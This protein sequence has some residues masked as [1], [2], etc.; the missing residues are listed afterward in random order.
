MKAFV[1]IVCILLSTASAGFSSAQQPGRS[2]GLAGFAASF[3]ETP[4]AEATGPAL[5]L[6]EAERIAL[7]RNPEIEVAARRVGAA[8]AHVPVAG[9]LDDP[10]VMYRAWGVPLQQPWNYNAAQNMFSISQ[11]FPGGGKR[12]LRT[13]VA[14]SDVDVAKARLDEVRL[15]VR[16]RVHK[17]FDDLLRADDE[18]RIH[19]EHVAI[20][21]QAIEAARIKYSVGKVSQQDILKAQVALTGLAEHM[22]RF[23][24]DADLAR[25]R[26]NTL[27]RRDPDRPLRVTGEFAVL[28]QLPSTQVLDNLALQSRPDLI[29]AEQAAKRSH[30]EQALAK[31]AYSP[32]FTVS[33]GYML[34][35]PGS[36][37]RN[38][39]MVEGS[40]TL[41]WLNHRKHDAEIAESTAQATEQD[42]ELDA[43][44]NAAFGQIQNALVEA[45]AA[46]RLAHLYRDELRPQAEA[47]LQSSVIA[48]ENDK[49]SFLDLLDSQMTVI[50]VDLAWL[51]AVADFDASLADLELATG[52]PLNQSDLPPAEVKP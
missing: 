20:A 27:L 4:R 11:T 29:A 21:R 26:L 15:E 28:A 7:A 37:M 50:N 34:M 17:A 42:A 13:S 3:Q 41:P 10:S 23:D 12:A 36:N 32:D 45:N 33:A 1:S 9:A 35:Q 25:A 51:N 6:D 49:T 14:E 44:R 2:D 39:Y 46:Q 24:H 22:I 43:L 19:D 47:T 40:M 48:Y 16:V 18:M 38:N 8:N 30:K 5:T 52:S 31:K